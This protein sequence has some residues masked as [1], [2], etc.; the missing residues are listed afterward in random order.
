MYIINKQLFLKEY[1]K[2]DGS[3]D[4]LENIFINAENGLLF[5]YIFDRRGLDGTD[6]INLSGPSGIIKYK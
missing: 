2:K 1:F 4:T 5:R 6:V 3:M